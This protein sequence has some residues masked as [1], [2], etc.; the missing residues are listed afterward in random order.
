MV[1]YRHLPKWMSIYHFHSSINCFLGCQFL[2]NTSYRFVFDIRN[3]FILLNAAPKFFSKPQKANATER[4]VVDKYFAGKMF[5]FYEKVPMS[6]GYN[7]TQIQFN[8]CQIFGCY[9]QIDTERLITMNRMCVCC[10]E[11]QTNSLC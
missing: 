6:H 5:A 9:G 2:Q 8:W 7:F 11:K 10:K 4:S 3:A 1:F